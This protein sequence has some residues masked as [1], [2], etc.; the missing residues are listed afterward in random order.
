MAIEEDHNDDGPPTTVD[1]VGGPCHGQFTVI[2]LCGTCGGLPGVLVPLGDGESAYYD[3]KPG[4]GHYGYGGTLP[5]AT[6]ERLVENDR[7]PST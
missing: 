2:N 6:A 4:L 1:F 3:W 7:D 5:T